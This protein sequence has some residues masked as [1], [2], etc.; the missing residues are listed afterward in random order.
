LSDRIKAIL[1]PAELFLWAWEEV[2][3]HDWEEFD[4]QWSTALGVGLNFL[5]IFA[6]INS[7]ASSNGND[8][9]EDYSRKPSGAFAWIVRSGSLMSPT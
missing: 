2:N 8:I 5:F 4:K 3:S 9:F 6:R 7:V 1:N